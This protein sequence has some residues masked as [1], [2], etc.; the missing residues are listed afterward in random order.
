MSRVSADGHTP[1][2]MPM[3]PEGYV[4]KLMQL[5]LVLYRMGLG[6]LLAQRIIVLSTRGR[7]T[8]LWR[9]VPL[10]FARDGEAV[11]VI[12]N[13]GERADWYRNLERNPD[14]TIQAGN[15]RFAAKAELL[16]RLDDLKAMLPV[17]RQ[18]V[19]VIDN[20]AQT[21]MGLDLS[22]EE[23]VAKVRAV[24]FTPTGYPPQSDF[25]A[26]LLWLWAIII[27]AALWLLRQ[28]LKRPRLILAILGQMVPVAIWLYRQYMRQQQGAGAPEMV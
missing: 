10:G 8:G 16:T 6:P 3:L 14:A 25:T 22:K 4:E 26:D 23:D 28:L 15:R 5:P 17:Y 24:R 2:I 7:K 13:R 12:S 1:T 21:M 20:I 27:P 18:A 11:Y 19:P 9:H